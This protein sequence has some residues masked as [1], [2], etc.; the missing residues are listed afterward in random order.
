MNGDAQHYIDLL[1]PYVDSY[2]YFVAFFG[3]MVENA[4]IPVPAE[5]ALI[6]LSFFASQGVLKIWW[7]IPIAILGDTAGDNIGYAIGRFGGRPLVDRYGKYVRLNAEKLDR[8]EAV[9]REKGG[10]T[11][12]FAHFLSSTRITAALIA[13]VSHMQYRRFLAFNVVAATTFVTLIA[14]VTYAFGSNLDAA[15]R[16]FRIYRWAAFA[17]LCVIA[18]IFLYRY[19]QRKKDVHNRLGL[20]I[21]VGAAIVVTLAGIVLYYAGHLFSTVTG[22]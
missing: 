10:R 13:G 22:V 4:G 1:A 18:A 9:F 3:M 6:T 12:Y 14:G 11:V 7:I 20:K 16:F 8:M 15:F 5:S 19:H 2:G 17:V 21:I